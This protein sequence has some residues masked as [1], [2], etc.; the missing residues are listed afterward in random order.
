M[1]ETILKPI[2][3]HNDHRHGRSSL[4]TS[5][6][7]VRHARRSLWLAL[8]LLGISFLSRPASAQSSNATINGTVRDQSGEVVTG[9]T[10]TATN[11]QTGTRKSETTDDTGRYTINNLVPGNYEIEVVKA[12][13]ATTLRHNQEVL[14]GTTITLDFSLPV[15]SVSQTVEVQAEDPVQQTTQDTVQQI[16]QTKELDNLPLVT[17]SFSDLAALTPGVLVGVGTVSSANISINNAPVGQ[18]GYLLDGHSNENDF[19]GGQFVNVAQDW[20]Q[21]FSVL[22]NQFPVEYGNAAAGFVSAVTRSGTNDLHGRVYGFFQDAA[23]NATPSFLPAFAPNKPPYSSQRIGGQAGGPIKQDKLFYFA[24]FE[25]YKNNTSI[26]IVVPAAFQKIPGSSGVYPQ[27][28]T[29]KLALLKLDYQPDAAD[30]FHARSNLEYDNAINSGIGAS[31]SLVHVLGNS[32][33]GFTP[34][35]LES[36]SW[37]RTLSAS[38][39][40]ELY[41]LYQ[42]N[43]AGSSCN[44]ET[45][46]GPYSGGGESATPFGDPVGYYAQVTYASAG[47]VTGC[48]VA[49]SNMDQ[50][51]GKL[52]DIFTL[53]K[54]S[55]TI[56]AGFEIDREHIYT[57]HFRNNYDGQ[58]VIAGTKPFTPGTASTYPLSLYSFYQP[59]ENTSWDFPTWEDS[60]FVQDSWRV[61]EN[62]TLNPGLRYDVSFSNSEYSSEGF[63][64][65]NSQ[66]HKINN[67]YGD[68]APRLGVAWTPFRDNKSTVLRGGL[69][70][71]YD[72][73][74]LQT[75]SAYISGFSKVTNGSNLNATRPS[76]NP[77]CLAVPSPCQGSVPANYASAVEEVLAYALA[78]Y[79]LPNFAPLGGTINLGGTTYTIPALPKIPGP[80]GTEVTAPKNFVFNID[81]NFKVP[82]SIQGTIGVQRQFGESLNVSADFAYSKLYNGVVLQNS[83]IDPVTYGLIDPNYILVESFTSGANV[84]SKHLLLH[85]GYNSHR[86]DTFQVSYSFGY[87]TDNAI[88][89]FITGSHTTQVTDPFDYNVD[90]GPS[91]ND[92]RNNLTAS[93]L[94][95]VPFGIEVAP[96]VFFSTALPYTAT[97]TQTTP[98]CLSYYSQC[99][100]VGYTRNSLRGDDTFQLNS[101]VSK[102]FHIAEKYSA[103]V[104]FEGFNLTNKLNT[105]VNFQ[106]SVLS[107]NFKKP[108]GQFTARRQLQAGFRFDF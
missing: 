35:Y 106:G 97:T 44:Y 47:V 91:P 25:Y 61:N 60:L 93:G 48:P 24:G 40:N 53:S 5:N 18:T 30:S 99:Y 71:F 10:V 63:T 15:T 51:N 36:L 76:L 84:W 1:L 42:K 98:G 70:L 72:Q 26:P 66:G 67:D 100:P 65:S 23:L 16:M 8:I 3:R 81:K 11:A 52:G 34:V 20:I 107:P 88:G 68:I 13:F 2:H 103:M 4:H 29:T 39:L 89:G 77:Y 22:T 54:G 83:N 96:T 49:F 46:V 37:T 32:T 79:S 56:K 69:G 80:G 92:A 9:A 58:Y 28:N 86:K 75:A 27:T 85:A 33:S 74:H 104:L 57:N 94:V 108:T 105:G 87:G 62:L 55:H 41:F 78:T 38:S 6:S 95:H 101:R 82:A 64:P 45:E 59:I 43:G 17:R 31:G 7:K 14:V 21:E 19:F 50:A 102:S 90:K 12:G 73:D